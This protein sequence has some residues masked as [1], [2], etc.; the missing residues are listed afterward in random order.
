MSSLMSKY[1]KY[2][3][4]STNQTTFLRPELTIKFMEQHIQALLTTDFNI[5]KGVKFLIKKALLLF[6]FILEM[7]N[8]TSLL[9]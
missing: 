6:N 8:T 9:I 7:Q 1:L 2:Y 5:L 4:I 3:P